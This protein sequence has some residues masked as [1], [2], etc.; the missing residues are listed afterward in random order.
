MKITLVTILFILMSSNAISETALNIEGVIQV[1][2]EIQKKLKKNGVLFIFAKKLGTRRGPPVSVV[3]IQNPKFPQKFSLG[4]KNIMIP[5]TK[6]KG[7]FVLSAR[8]SADGNALSKNNSFQ[9]MSSKKGGVLSGDKNIKVII[10]KE[11]L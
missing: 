5:G 1:T 8:F 9:G 11:Y 7:P 2:P 10:N 4:P 3:R 6:F